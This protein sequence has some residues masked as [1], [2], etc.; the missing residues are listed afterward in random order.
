MALSSSTS[1]L[2]AAASSPAAPT[3]PPASA[4]RQ[5][6]VSPPVMAAPSLRLTV[7]AVRSKVASS[8]PAVQVAAGILARSVA[9]RES[10]GEGKEDLQGDVQLFGEDDDEDPQEAI[11]AALLQAEQ[12]RRDEEEE[13][14]M[15]IKTPADR[16]L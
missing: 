8:Q 7:G 15:I 5:L 1:A 14:L 13:G 16:P 11:A 12:L 6:I 9:P 2:S 4:Q 10:L 3:A